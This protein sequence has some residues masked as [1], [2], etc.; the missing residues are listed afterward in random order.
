MTQ[1]GKQSRFVKPLMLPVAQ[2]STGGTLLQEQVD[3]LQRAVSRNSERMTIESLAQDAVRRL[4]D[5]YKAGDYAR[6]AEI[7]R[8]ICRLEVYLARRGFIL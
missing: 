6:A 4:A 7:T 5:A 2:M 8:E 3:L 1:A